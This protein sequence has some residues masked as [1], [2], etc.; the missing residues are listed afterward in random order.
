MGG[1]KTLG[2]WLVFYPP[3]GIGF[4]AVAHILNSPSRGRF[5]FV[6]PRGSLFPAF[7]REST[8][9]TS[10]GGEFPEHLDGWERGALC[11]ESPIAHSLGGTKIRNSRITT[12]IKRVSSKVRR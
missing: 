8:K 3:P 5:F 4:E 9:N 1:K 12:D 6:G 11:L 2:S 10:T 7:W